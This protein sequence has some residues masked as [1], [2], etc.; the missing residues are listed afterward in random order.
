MLPTGLQLRKVLFWVSVVGLSG[1]ASGSITATDHGASVC[2]ESAR[3]VQ[4]LA[5]SVMI[6]WTHSCAEGQLL[7]L[8]WRKQDQEQ[9]MG[10]K[11]VLASDNSAVTL[12][13]KEGQVYLFQLA[14]ISSQG[15][16][17]LQTLLV[18][19]RTHNRATNVVSAPGNMTGTLALEWN[20]AMDASAL[21]QILSILPEGE[22]STWGY[23]LESAQSP[24][25][26]PNQSS[27]TVHN[28]QP[29]TLHHV[30]VNT[31]FGDARATTSSLN[32]VP[33]RTA[34]GVPDV[35]QNLRALN[36]TSTSI[37]I[38]WD[39]LQGV[40]AGLFHFP[41]LSCCAVRGAD[42]ARHGGAWAGGEGLSVQY[43]VEVAGARG[44]FPDLNPFLLPGTP[45]TSLRVPPTPPGTDAVL[46]CYGA[47][48]RSP[49]LNLLS[50]PKASVF[51]FRSPFSRA[52]P[53]FSAVARCLHFRRRRLT[54]TMA[55]R[56]SV[57]PQLRRPTGSSLPPASIA[58]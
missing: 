42:G 4:I 3:A 35:V 10:G 46:C 34:A 12:D 26:A 27:F 49:V 32:L 1:L 23:N 28:L 22:S 44:S 36:G 43:I 47:G 21:G 9:W 30:R 58:P 45:P 17:G 37:S 33:R 7:D 54:C 51:R 14:Q 39:A 40:T 19:T 41:S 20:P 56:Q 25:L 48:G 8:Q 57:R 52:L 15:H 11:E 18:E 6:S 31:L 55:V 29:H 13:L 5:S 24:I 53:P 38:T 2:L 16:A 50:L